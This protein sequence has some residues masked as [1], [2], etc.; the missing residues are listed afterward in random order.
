MAY[1]AVTSSALCTNSWNNIYAAMNTIS[2]PDS[3]HT[4]WIYSAHPDKEHM[5]KT[6]YPLI[7]VNPV[8]PSMD[9]LTM[10]SSDLKQVTLPVSIEVY[11]K[12]A[13]ELD[14]VCD[15]VYSKMVSVESTLSGYKMDCMRLTGS[16]Y[17]IFTPSGTE[18]KIHVRNTDFEFRFQHS[19]S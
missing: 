3:R 10:G 11:A 16:I 5:E 14:T 4:K 9:A 12:S 17:S 15:L 2:D 8:N 19:G 6:D 18:W 13:D 7:V 1:A